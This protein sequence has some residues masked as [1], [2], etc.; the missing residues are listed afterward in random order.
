MDPSLKGFIKETARDAGYRK[1]ARFLMLLGKEEAARVL[2]HLTPD[3]VAGVTLEIAKTQKIDQSEAAKIL[4]EFG[5]IRET[6]D[7]IA[8]GGIA[9][10]EEMLVGALGREKADEI[11]SRVKKDMAPPPFSFLMDVDFHQ[12]V[13]LM[14]EESPPVIA[15][16][17]AHLEP[18]L[19]ARVLAALSPEV[20]KETVPR[21][22]RLSKVDP[23]VVRKTEE[24]LRSKI[25]ETGTVVTEDV[26]G[27]S[28]LTEILRFMDPAR[29]AAILE[30]LDPNTAEE[31]KKSLFTQ[32]VVFRIPDKDL[33]KAL[34]NYADREIAL[35][36]KGAEETFSSRI[37]ESISERRREFIR[38]EMEAMG[39]T[40]KSKINQALDD[41][42][43][44]L[45]L[46][47]QK[48]EI[49]IPREREE[50][51]Q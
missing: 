25:R 8:S 24:A 40:L 45:Q 12:T 5:Y 1:A 46:L 26:N 10:A 51:V 11:L 37:M 29:E 41:F 44:Y 22:A 48:G 35:M 14:K 18:R 50:F 21:I 15:L 7:L 13:S 43:S 30:D 34:H 4:E 28:A 16:I 2:K 31:I 20:Q 23:E 47:E 19:A 33:Q 36:L 49:I 32:E 6:K 27:K 39:P 17:L 3:E 9:K 38:S 42:L